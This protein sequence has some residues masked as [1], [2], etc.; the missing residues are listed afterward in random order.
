[1]SIELAATQPAGAADIVLANGSDEG[2]E[3]MESVAEP[4]ST[5]EPTG[6]L[7]W[8]GRRSREGTTSCAAVL[9]TQSAAKATGHD[10]DSAMSGAD[11][12]LGKFVEALG[13]VFT[14]DDEV[15]REWR[16]ALGSLLAGCAGLLAASCPVSL[17]TPEDPRRSQPRGIRR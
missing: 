1:M 2:R 13:G 6:L 5:S 7:R 11:A 16:Q 15:R 10:H 9:Q 4:T 17:R 8:H 3:T 12:A 14:W